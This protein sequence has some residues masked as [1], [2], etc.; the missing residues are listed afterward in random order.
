[1]D[2]HIGVIFLSHLVYNKYT[3][4]TSEFSINNVKLY[5]D[6]NIKEMIKK[7]G[8]EFKFEDYE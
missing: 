3:N 7:Y 2:I 1:M 4:K 5:N 6:K 8:Y